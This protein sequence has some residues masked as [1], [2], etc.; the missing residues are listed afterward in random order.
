VCLEGD[1]VNQACSLY[2]SVPALIATAQTVFRPRYMK[3]SF[4]FDNALVTEC[5]QFRL[6][7]GA[8]LGV[9]RPINQLRLGQSIGTA[10]REYVIHSWNRP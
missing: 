9:L 2:Q 7:R 10:S 4:N 3:K 5:A 1:V 8:H 6:P